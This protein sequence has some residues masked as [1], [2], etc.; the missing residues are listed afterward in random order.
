MRRGPA[1]RFGAMIAASA[2]A[3]LVLTGCAGGTDATTETESTDA[4]TLVPAGEG[5]TEYPLTLETP[6][7]DT[8]LDAQPQRIAV[9]TASTIDTDALL[10]LDV[11]PVMAPTTVER[12]VWLDEADVTAIETLWESEAGAD[13][14]PEEVAASKPDLIVTLNAYDTFDTHYTSRGVVG[15]NWAP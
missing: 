9:V 2:A 4:A 15:R 3:L 5:T 13:V 10:A 1:A 8:E 12:N 14:S 7:G 11:I 6:F